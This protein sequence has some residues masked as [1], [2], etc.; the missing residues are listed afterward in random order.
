MWLLPYS[1]ARMALPCP[2]RV[3]IQCKSVHAGGAADDKQK[4]A[5]TLG[6]HPWHRQGWRVVQQRDKS[7]HVQICFVSVHN[8]GGNHAVCSL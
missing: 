3:K 4:A 1:T 7:I 2:Y 8:T 5:C 6:M